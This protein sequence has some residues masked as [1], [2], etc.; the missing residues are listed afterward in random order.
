MALLSI[1]EAKRILG[2]THMPI[3]QLQEIL[4]LIEEYAWII[5]EQI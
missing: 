2:S 4:Q 5:T 1:T 3:E